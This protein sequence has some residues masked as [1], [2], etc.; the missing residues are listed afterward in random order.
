MEAVNYKVNEVINLINHFFKKMVEGFE[1][2]TNGVCTPEK[3]DSDL[4]ESYLEI[5]N[6]RA[7][8]KIEKY[9]DEEIDE[10]ESMW[11]QLNEHLD[12]LA[13]VL[14]EQFEY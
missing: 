10:L 2:V 8:I 13:D 5:L 3:Y 14:A 7:E 6:M 9:S 11:Y 12:G 4:T 1:L